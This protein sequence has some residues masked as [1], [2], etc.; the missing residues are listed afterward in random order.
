MTFWSTCNWCYVKTLIENNDIDWLRKEVDSLWRLVSYYSNLLEASFWGDKEK[1]LKEMTESEE[2]LA[3]VK[4]ALE[5]LLS[6]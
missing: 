5:E 4:S 2:K 3:C 1:L 6:D